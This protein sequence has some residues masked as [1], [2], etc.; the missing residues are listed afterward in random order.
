MWGILAPV[1]DGIADEIL[2]KLLKM[3]FVNAHKRQPVELDVRG[4]D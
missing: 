4:S 1:L 2:K 3:D